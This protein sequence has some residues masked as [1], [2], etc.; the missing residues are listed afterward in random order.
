MQ[1][2]TSWQPKQ[3]LAT[4]QHLIH[5]LLIAPGGVKR[6]PPLAERRNLSA[7]ATGECTPSVRPAG[8]ANVYSRGVECRGQQREHG[9]ERR[10]LHS[11]QSTHS[12]TCAARLPGAYRRFLR[13]KLRWEMQARSR[14][15]PA[16]PHLVNHGP[17]DRRRRRRAPPAPCPPAVAWCRP[18]DVTYQ[19]VQPRGDLF[20]TCSQTGRLKWIYLQSAPPRAGP[21]GRRRPPL[22]TAPPRKAHSSVPAPVCNTMGTPEFCSRASEMEAQ[23]AQ[24]LLPW[25][26]GGVGRG[27]GEA[28]G[29]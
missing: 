2:S 26:C 24:R 11:L 23:S 15:G 17:L 20:S 9:G 14:E 10:Q 29:A 5:D 8:P 27:A 21:L 13:L 6:A 4:R 12:G 22:D 28:V 19:N 16:K 25:N 3:L 18:P 1:P 7:S